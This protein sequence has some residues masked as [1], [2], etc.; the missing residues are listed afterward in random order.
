MPMETRDRGLVSCL[1]S[2][3]GGHAVSSSPDELPA[4]LVNLDAPGA[5]DTSLVLSMIQAMVDVPTRAGFI[6]R[7]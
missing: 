2:Q 6:P 7:S 3:N 5:G 4:R 1:S